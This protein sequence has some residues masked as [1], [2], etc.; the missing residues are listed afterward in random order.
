[1]WRW[2]YEELNGILNAAGHGVATKWRLV[3]AE[4]VS[5]TASILEK[6]AWGEGKG[7]PFLLKLVITPTNERCLGYSGL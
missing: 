3:Q 4:P 2:L 5:V 6:V 1:M 7:A